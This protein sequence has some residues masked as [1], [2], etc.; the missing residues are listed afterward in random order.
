[1]LRGVLAWRVFEWM[2]DDSECRV[3]SSWVER[4]AI[5]FG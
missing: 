3:L 4:T 2:L 1:M 5:L